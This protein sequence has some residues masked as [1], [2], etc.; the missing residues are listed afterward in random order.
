MLAV[1]RFGWGSSLLILCVA[2]CSRDDPLAPNFQAS[3][4]TLSAPSNATA[5]AISS[6]EIAVTWRDNSDNEDGFEVYV[7][8]TS[9]RT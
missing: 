4:R 3:K 1:R 7:A 5:T 9:P 6:S 2:S 8:S